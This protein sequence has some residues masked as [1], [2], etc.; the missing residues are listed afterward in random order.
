MRGHRG[1]VDIFD[2][3]NPLASINDYQWPLIWGELM[4][5]ILAVP[6]YQQLF[7]AA[8]PEVPLAELG[9]EHAANA[10]AA[11]QMDTF[12][13]LDSP[14]DRYLQGDSTALSPEAQAGAELFYGEAG[15]AQCHSGP[16]LTDLQ[17]HNIGVPQIG[18]GKGAEEPYDFGRARE[19]GDERDLFAFRTPPLRNVAI[20]GPWMHNGAY[21]TLEAAVLHHLNPAESVANYDF[22][23]LSAHLLAE[24]SGDTAVHTAPLNAPSF[25]MP[26]R[27][28][29]DAEIAALLTF[30]EALTSPSALDLSHTIPDS[31][32]S[33]L[34]VG[35]NIR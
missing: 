32:P 23:Q 2:K 12:T 3:R 25:A 21:L 24:D 1:Q 4:T 18:P 30:L 6:A 19:T 31:V 34:P 35:G 8:Y 14:W 9:F 22:S 33:G 29:T 13:F 17:F 15:C 20:T 28:L 26:S 5:E 7:L 10:L 16:L 27:N 11:Y